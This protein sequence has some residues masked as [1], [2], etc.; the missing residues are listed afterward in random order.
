MA[1]ASKGVEFE[2]SIGL[3]VT[4][5]KSSAVVLNKIAHLRRIITSCEAPGVDELS[6]GLTMGLSFR[7]RALSLD[8]LMNGLTISISGIVECLLLEQD[9]VARV[10]VVASQLLCVPIANRINDDVGVGF[11]LLISV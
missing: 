1:I 8:V 2:I 4:T 7:S 3:D 10:D 9:H 11:A 6:P 5:S